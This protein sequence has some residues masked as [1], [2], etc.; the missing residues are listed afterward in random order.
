MEIPDVEL[1]VQGAAAADAQEVGGE[2]DEDDLCAGIKATNAH[3]AI[4]QRLPSPAAQLPYTSSSRR[5]GR[6]PVEAKPKNLPRFLPLS[7]L[8]A[9]PKDIVDAQRRGRVLSVGGVL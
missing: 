5:G 9:L 8:P 2:E 4:P 7:L 1:V 6:E 3:G